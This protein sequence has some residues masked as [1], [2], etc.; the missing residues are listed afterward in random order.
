MASSLKSD[1]GAPCDAGKDSRQALPAA[2]NEDKLLSKIDFKVM[3]ML[4]VIYVAAFLGR[5]VST[6]ARLSG[7]LVPT[8]SQSQYL[9]YSNLWPATR[10]ALGRHRGECRFDN[11]LCTLRTFWDPFQHLDKAFQD[12]HLV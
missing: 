3:P 8:V 11:V 7:E 4:F 12:T 5:S 1:G 2:V 6:Q 9:Q 10:P